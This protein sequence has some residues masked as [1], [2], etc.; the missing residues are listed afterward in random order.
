MQVWGI[1]PIIS[2]IGIFW[3]LLGAAGASGHVDPSHYGNDTTSY[4]QP[5]QLERL[6]RVVGY[7]EGWGSRRVCNDFW[8][9]MIP[10]A[11]YTHL[12]FAFATIDPETYEVMPAHKADVK[13][14]SRLTGKKRG[15]TP[16]KVFIAFGGPTFN[17]PGPTQRTFSD[18][19][20]SP[21]NQKKFLKSLVSFMSTYNFD[22][23]D[24]NWEYSHIGEWLGRE[25][26]FQNFPKFLKSLKS[27]LNKTPGRNGISIS[28]PSSPWYLEHFDMKE[29]SESVDFF[30]M[31][32]YDL[33]GTWSRGN[34]QTGHA[35]TGD[36]LNGHTNLTEI[37]MALDLLWK[38]DIP[39][40]K[41]VMGLAFHGRSYIIGDDCSEP[42]C[43]YLSGGVDAGCSSETGV[44]FNADIY[45]VREASQISGQIHDLAVLY[46]EA[47]I[48]VDKLGDK[49]VSY[50][51]ADT[52]RL[53]IKY[54]EMESLGGVMVWAVSRDTKKSD[55][56]NMLGKITGLL[57]SPS[58]WT[59]D[60]LFPG[61][62]EEVQA[63]EEALKEWIKNPSC[64]GDMM[65]EL[66]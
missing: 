14:Y 6:E 45:K 60:T 3:L 51:D 23:V 28:I 46:E 39:K 53:K 29:L 44:I 66:V 64:S 35:W 12:N 33:H 54:A 36:Y 63:F 17:G 7:F 2:T 30:N 58:Y 57:E 56:S 40:S 11:I 42:G 24:F 9:E 13:L 5:H 59:A 1:S 47:A 31:M 10:D 65:N 8:P 27:T 21:Q 19:A 26:D 50:D 62:A 41:V 22:G 55:Y 4:E 37:D 15:S 20:A 43:V 32:T 61:E 18:I 34:L 48:K 52:F 16:L 38:K 25:E 49:W